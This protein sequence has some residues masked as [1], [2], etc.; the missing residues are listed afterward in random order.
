MFIDF[1]NYDNTL[2]E[3]GFN[4]KSSNTWDLNSSRKKVADEGIKD[5]LFVEY[6][7][8]PFDKLWIYQNKAIVERS[9]EEYLWQIDSSNPAVITTRQLASLPFSHAYITN[10]V[11][12]I[13]L[14][15]LKTKESSY[16]F[17]LW[18]YETDKNN[19]NQQGLIDDTQGSAGKTSNIKQDF[20]KLLSLSYKQTISPVD[21][22]YYVYAVLY[23]NIYRKKYEEFLKIDFPKIP[24]TSQYD[25][26]KEVSETGKQLADLHLLKSPLLNKSLS[27]FEGRNGEFVKKWHFDEQSRRVYINEKQYFSNVD[28]AIWN[29][30]I[31]GYQVLDKWLKERKDKSLS[32]EEI[33]HFIKIIEAL[34]HTLEIQ[35]KIDK[36][37]PDT[38]RSI[39]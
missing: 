21:V 13:C 29:Y 25:L 32:S 18:L 20:I 9:R 14:I 1:D 6:N 19:N 22:F 12:D 38:E 37:Y 7:Y 36:I 5:E 10:S 2:L 4:L 23:S 15:S 34:R 30:F 3:Q 27:K 35:D 16:V 24:F 31:G 8:R 11:P 28:S 26:F 33:N 17:P 39:I